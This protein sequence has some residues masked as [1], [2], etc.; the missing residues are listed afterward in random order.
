MRGRSNSVTR[1]DLYQA[2]QRTAGV[3]KRESEKLVS[4][5]LEEIASS[6]ERGET[7]KLTSFGIFFV[8][9][10]DERLGRNPRTG[11]PVTI[12]PRRVVSFKP[13]PVLKRQI[14]AR[15]EQQASVT[16]SDEKQPA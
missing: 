16:K 6:L 12:S 13:S 5:I 11:Q 10:K 8:R 2:V 1:E 7:V 3:S 15:A 14:N 4:Q 9:Q